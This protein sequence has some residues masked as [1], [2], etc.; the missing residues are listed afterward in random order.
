MKADAEE[1]QQ[2]WEQAKSQL[3]RAVALIPIAE[4]NAQRQFCIVVEDSWN[5]LNRALKSVE[6]ALLQGLVEPSDVPLDERITCKLIAE[7]KRIPFR[8]RRSQCLFKFRYRSLS[9]ENSKCSGTT[10]VVVRQPGRNIG[11]QERTS[12]MPSPFLFLFL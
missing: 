2:E 7:G 1:Q 9:L 11:A 6:K 4:E 12:G 8:R 5:E 3:S 10:A